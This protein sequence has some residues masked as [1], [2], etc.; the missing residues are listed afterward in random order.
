MRTTARP[1]PPA[2]HTVRLLSRLAS[3]TAAVCQEEGLTL[4]QYRML[5]NIS[6]APMRAGDLAVR[7]GR[8]RAT[9]T[10]IVRGLERRGL[11]ERRRVAGDGRGVLIGLTRPGEELL[12][13]LDDALKAFLAQ[14]LAEADRAAFEEMIGGLEDAIEAAAQRIRARLDDG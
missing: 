1:A 14:L 12:A 8:S 5:V 11:L 3:V 6:A 7:L 13:S 2:L 10:A 4:S 9:L